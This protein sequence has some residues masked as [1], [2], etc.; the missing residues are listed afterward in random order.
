MTVAF[1]RKLVEELFLIRFPKQKIP[2]CLGAVTI[3][4]LGKATDE[5]D[6]IE[7]MEEDIVEQVSFQTRLDF[8]S[9]T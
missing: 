2:F 3:D 6:L 5:L 1:G 8:S 4:A 7:G 9:F